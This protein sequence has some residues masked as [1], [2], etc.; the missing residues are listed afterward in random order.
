MTTYIFDSRHKEAK[1]A[2]FLAI[3]QSGDENQEFSRR[4]QKM[5]E[6][7]T[8]ATIV[9]TTAVDTTRK[10]NSYTMLVVILTRTLNWGGNVG[11]FNAFHTCN[12]FTFAKSG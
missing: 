5:A 12:N 10:L 8:F 3:R 4:F 7:S 1:M 11:I 6:F 2:T 9:V